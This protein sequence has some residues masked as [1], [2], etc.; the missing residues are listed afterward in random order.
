MS[1]LG[2][3]GKDISTP[4]TTR[5]Q[6]T[7]FVGVP[8]TWS[9]TI[10]LRATTSFTEGPTSMIRVNRSPSPPHGGGSGPSVVEEEDIDLVNGRVSDDWV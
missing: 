9:T 3:T 5:V 1:A 10:T 7:S 2:G 6:G 4:I 8:G